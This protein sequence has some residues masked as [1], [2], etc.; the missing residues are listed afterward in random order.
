MIGDFSHGLAALGGSTFLTE[1]SGASTGKSGRFWYPF[2]LA[3]RKGESAPSWK[4]SL[5]LNLD[6]VPGAGFG[7]GET[8]FPVVRSSGGPCYH[9]SR[10]E[11]GGNRETLRN[12]APRLTA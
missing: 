10:P 11:D 5:S 6:S 8:F 9:Q 4:T 1:A 7:E 12:P 2:A 3:F